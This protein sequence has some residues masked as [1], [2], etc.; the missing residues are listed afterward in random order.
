MTSQ[1][2]LFFLLAIVLA[3]GSFFGPLDGDIPGDPSSALPPAAPTSVEILAE[4]E[5]DTVPLYGA[6]DSNEVVMMLGKTEPLI[7]LGT[8]GERYRV[9]A[10]DGTE[11]FVPRYLVR[12]M[13]V[14]PKQDFIVLGYFMQDTGGTGWSSLH[15]H[16]H[17]IRALSPWSWGVTAA[18][19]LRPVYFNE[20]H[21]AD[22]LAFAGRH[23][24]TTHALIHNFNPDKGVFDA[25]LA[26]RVLSDPAVRRRT[27]ENIIETV[28][29]WDMNGVHIDFEGVTAARRHDLTAFVAELASAATPRNLQISIAVPAKTA[30]TRGGL[31]VE[32]YD[33]EALARHADFVVIM[34]YDQHWRGDAAGP[35]AAVP[36]VRDVVEYALDPAGGA[37][38]ADKLVLGVPAYGYDWPANGPW[39]DAVA[40]RQAMDRLASAAG[41]DGSVALKWHNTH[42]APYFTYEGRTV[43]FENEHSVAYKLMLARE[44]NLAGIALW[45]LGQEDGR[46]WDLVQRVTG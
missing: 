13:T 23:G 25:A 45:R 19:D 43:W 16:V 4:A 1:A 17:A 12:T 39:A 5:G 35:V 26:D 46:I 10:V 33:Y 32:A 8:E 11:G 9:R 20:A 42:K 41:R 21:L 34:A 27:V 2:V 15:D 40:H 30:A 37:I 44:Y 18:G 22:V 6:S 31:W 36:W 3:F 14:R 24:V 38:P 29:R 7:V 28:T